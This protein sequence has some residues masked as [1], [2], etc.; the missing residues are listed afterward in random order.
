MM[1]D[2]LDV[3]LDFVC[4][5]FIEYFSSIFIREIGLKFSFCAESLCG[6]GIR[7]IVDS[8]KECA[9]APSV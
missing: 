2:F 6:L 3:F 4:N 1:D 7:V 5:N 8:Y 9:S